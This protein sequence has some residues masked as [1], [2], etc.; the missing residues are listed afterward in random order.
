MVGLPP[1]G[2]HDRQAPIRPADRRGLGNRTAHRRRKVAVARCAEATQD[3]D[4]LSLRLRRLLGAPAHADQYPQRRSVLSYPRLHRRRAQPRRPRIAAAFPV[5]TRHSTLPLDPKH[6]NHAEAKKMARRL[7]SQHPSTS[8]PIKYALG[9][10]A[11]QRNA[12]KARLTK[13]KP[14]AITGPISP[15]ASA[16]G[17]RRMDTVHWTSLALKGLPSCHFTPSCRRNVSSVLS[18]FHD[19]PAAR[20]GTIDCKT[21]LRYILLVYDEVIED[22]HHRASAASVASSWID[23]LAGPVP[24][25]DLEDSALL[26]RIRR[27]DNAQSNQQP[28]CRR[29]PAK[30]SA[31]SHL[32]VLAFARHS[33]SARTETAH[34]RALAQVP[35]PI[36]HPFARVAAR[37]TRRAAWL[38]VEPDVLHTQAVVDAVDHRGIPFDIRMPAGPRTVMPEDRTGRVLR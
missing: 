17:P 19:Q 33:R 4:R 13:N 1:L 10:I 25:V 32:P 16:R 24:V 38:L 11:N 27:L 15:C 23:M 8:L 30:M 37:H 9:R 26:L 34:S 31:H 6:P 21:G 2:V 7:R 5:S 35:L 3:L 36:Y 29:E 18:S 28:A 22:T 20:S 14:P 12:A